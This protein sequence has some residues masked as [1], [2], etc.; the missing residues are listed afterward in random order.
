MTTAS[1]AVLFRH[2]VKSIAQAAP[3][4]DALILDARGHVHPVVPSPLHLG[5][6]RVTARGE[7]SLRLTN[8]YWEQRLRDK[9]TGKESVRPTLPVCGEFHFARCNPEFWEDGL[10]KMKACG[11]TA[12]STYVFWI[13]HEPEEGRFDWRDRRDLRRFVDLCARQGLDVYLRTGPF[14]HGEMR[15]G[16]LPDWLY[17]KP[18]EVRSNDPAYL[19]CVQRFY[20]EIGRQIQDYLWQSGGPIAGIQLENEF[21]AASAP[22]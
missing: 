13:L 14:A 15:N 17:G 6:T 8:L 5:G 9:V 2:G 12:V 4:E 22:W 3:G 19:A 18:F 10:R 11:V 1:A 21:M 20:A 7:E 16:G